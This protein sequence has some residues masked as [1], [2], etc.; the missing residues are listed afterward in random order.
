[1]RRA[2][3]VAG[4]VLMALGLVSLFVIIPAQVGGEAGHA[5]VAPDLFPLTL[6]ALVT[7]LAALLW[8]SRLARRHADDEPAPLRSE[9]FFFIVAASAALAASFLAVTYLGFIAGSIATVAFAALVMDG[10]RHPVRLAV[11]SL[12]APVAIWAVF[13]HLFTVLLP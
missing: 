1:M 4:L 12:A 6:M 11:V 8:I 2:D 13:R 5:G 10:R 3:I 9:N 7:G